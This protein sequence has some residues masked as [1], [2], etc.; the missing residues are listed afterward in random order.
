M[1]TA[2]KICPACKSDRIS[3]WMGANLGAQYFCKACGYRGPLVVE[4][5]LEK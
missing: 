3:L 2:K 1:I 4:E 5:E